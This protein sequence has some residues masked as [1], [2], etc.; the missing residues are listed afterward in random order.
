MKAETSPV[1]LWVTGE[2]MFDGKRNKNNP[3]V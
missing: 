3:L 1:G 2:L